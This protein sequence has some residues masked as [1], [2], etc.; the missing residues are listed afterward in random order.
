MKI[1]YDDKETVY[2]IDLEYP[3][4]EMYIRA[5]NIAEVREMFIE[6]MAWLFDLTLREQ[7]KD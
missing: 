4:T 6:R 2:H 3:E 7:L 5:D 1:V